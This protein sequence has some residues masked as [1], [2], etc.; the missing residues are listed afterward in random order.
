MDKC[1][2]PRAKRITTCPLHYRFTAI[3]DSDGKAWSFATGR[4]VG[5]GKIALT[6]DEK[7][8]WE[9]AR[10]RYAPNS[11]YIASNAPADIPGVAPDGTKIMP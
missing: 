2:T 5:A 7:A 6:L 8:A 10:V 1:C 11:P 9:G 4:L 3:P